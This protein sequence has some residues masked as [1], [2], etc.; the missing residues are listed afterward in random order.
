MS[1]PV[2]KDA[3]VLINEYLIYLARM[4]VYLIDYL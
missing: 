2:T 1:E 3:N 4:R